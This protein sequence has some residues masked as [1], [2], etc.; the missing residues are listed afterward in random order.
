MTAQYRAALHRAREEQRRVF[1]VPARFDTASTTTELPLMSSARPARH[2]AP[3]DHDITCTSPRPE[4]TTWV[5]QGSSAVLLVV[6]RCLTCAAHA[7][8]RA[9]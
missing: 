1:G 7:R 5:R 8:E 3:I 9:T 4:S 6:T 2:H